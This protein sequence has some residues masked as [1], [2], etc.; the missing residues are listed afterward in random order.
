MGAPFTDMEEQI[1]TAH[2]HGGPGRVRFRTI[3]RN[4]ALAIGG[5]AVGSFALAWL[6]FTQVTAAGV[7]LG[8]FVAWYA[9]FLLMVWF[10]G[11]EQYDAVRARDD[12][13]PRGARR[14]D[15]D[16]RAHLQAEQEHL[17]EARHG[18]VPEPPAAGRRCR[19][20]PHP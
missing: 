4:D 8:M 1:L 11:K 14:P 12:D 9:M 10:I 16:G 2:D 20:W 19:K 5:A 13:H 6:L 3:E 15:E 7:N 17:P 18:R